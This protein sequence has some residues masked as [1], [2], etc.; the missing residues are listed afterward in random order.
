MKILIAI[1]ASLIITNSGIGISHGI[2][3]NDDGDGKLFNGEPYYN[4]I[5]YAR[6]EGAKAGDEIITFDIHR[7]LDDIIF[8]A[9]WVLK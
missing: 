5:S 6:V 1:I 3:L 9:D 4:Y 7:N 8:R 2:M